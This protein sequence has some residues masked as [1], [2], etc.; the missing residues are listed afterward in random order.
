MYQQNSELFIDSFKSV[1]SSGRVLMGPDV[2]VFERKIADYCQRKFAIAVGSCT[3]ALFFSLKA[4]GIQPGDEVLVTGFSFIASASPILRIGAIPVFVDINPDTF[5]MSLQDLRSKITEKTKVI[6][7]VHL[8]GQVLPFDDL[9]EI[10]AA[11]HIPIIEDAAQSLGSYYKDLPAGNLGK[12]SCISFDPTKVISAFGNG[13]V[14]LTDDDHLHAQIAKMRYHGKNI[15]QGGFDILGY[16]S[17][18]TT[19]QAAMLKIQLDLLDTW[20]A[21]RN[22]IASIYNKELSQIEQVSTPSLSPNST[23]TYHKYVLKVEDRDGLRNCLKMQG[24]QTMI[25]YPSAIFDWDVFKSHHR[26]VDK[27]DIIPIVTQEVLSLP[28]YPELSSEEAL[29]ICD[30]IRRYYE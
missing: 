22:T 1:M 2:D 24:V 11:N 26:V 14:V 6:V 18:L 15:Q 21:K 20:V 30:S 4:M 9:I 17:R 3:D 13:G 12:T 8:F 29:Y 25:H 5:M 28:I 10:S 27:I 16:N 23:H 19:H 7:A